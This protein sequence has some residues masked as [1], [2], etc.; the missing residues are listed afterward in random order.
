MATAKYIAEPQSLQ[1]PELD[2]NTKSPMAGPEQEHE[3]E[4]AKSL[5][6]ALVKP[7]TQA[8]LNSPRFWAIL[9]ALGFTGLLTALDATITSTALPSIVADL[10]GGDLYIWAI[11]GYLLTLSVIRIVWVVG[12]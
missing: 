12:R 6:K 4:K 3:T 1:E 10:G 9:I 7:I 11:D 5:D 2:C 8:N